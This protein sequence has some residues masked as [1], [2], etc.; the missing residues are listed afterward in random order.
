MVLGCFSADF[1]PLLP[2][3]P[4]TPTFLKETISDEETQTKVWLTVVA[5]VLLEE[6]FGEKRGEWELIFQK[7]KSFL[8]KQGAKEIMAMLMQEARTMLTLL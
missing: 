3:T 1:L 7:A 6:R 5:M 4:E 8:R 2:Q